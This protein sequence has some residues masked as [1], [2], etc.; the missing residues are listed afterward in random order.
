MR[1][2][3]RKSS[4]KNRD[5]H[6]DD[7]ISYQQMINTKKLEFLQ[8]ELHPILEDADSKLS[9]YNFSPRRF[10]RY[11]RFTIFLKKGEND[12]NNKFIVENT[13]SL[14]PQ[15]LAFLMDNQKYASI[16]SAVEIN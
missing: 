9:L 11:P 15:F 6:Q 14:N 10:N 16:K 13:V 2:F 5:L 1:R 8:S 4:S 3:Q 12:N 7:R